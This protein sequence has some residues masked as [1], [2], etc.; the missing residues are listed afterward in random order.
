MRTKAAEKLTRHRDKAL[1]GSKAAPAATK[2][3]FAE[4]IA[5]APQRLATLLK[6]G[7]PTLAEALEMKRVL[8]IK[9]EEWLQEAG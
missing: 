4:S 1:K 6:G 7:T 5:M 8:R 2:A 9:P 3:G